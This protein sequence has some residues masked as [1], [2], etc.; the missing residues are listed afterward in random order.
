MKSCWELFTSIPALQSD[1]FLSRQVNCGYIMGNFKH[2][3]V[4][5][6]KGD[7]EGDY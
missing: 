5:T 1:D 2:A 6:Q 3:V 4:S 7:E